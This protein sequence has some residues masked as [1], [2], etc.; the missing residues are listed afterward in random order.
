[1]KGDRSYS[2][3]GVRLRP[4]QAGLLSALDEDGANIK[5]PSIDH[6]FE[7]PDFANLEELKRAVL[8]FVERLLPA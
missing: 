4:R 5:G 7:I 6:R 8:V 2:C 1:M 3:F